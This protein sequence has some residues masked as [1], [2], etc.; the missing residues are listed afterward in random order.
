MCRLLGKP[1]LKQQVRLGRIYDSRL[2]EERQSANCLENTD[3][4]RQTVTCCPFIKQFHQ[5]LFAG[6]ANPRTLLGVAYN[7]SHGIILRQSRSNLPTKRKTG[8][9][10][11]IGFFWDRQ[12]Q[13][14]ILEGLFGRQTCPGFWK[15]WLPY[16][17]PH[18]ITSRFSCH[19]AS[20]TYSLEVDIFSTFLHPFSLPLRTCSATVPVWNCRKLLPTNVSW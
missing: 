9:I 8:W 16:I 6:R 20:H 11:H 3:W 2:V 5:F 1:Y 13:V 15:T 10:F 12:I 17:V 14:T 18:V 19:V 7:Q 4:R